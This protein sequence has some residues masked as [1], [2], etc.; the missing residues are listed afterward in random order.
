M[1]A[2]KFE[3]KLKEFDKARRLYERALSDLGKE[4]LDENFLIQ[5]VK[6]EIKQKEFDRAKILF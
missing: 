3:E 1:K 2:A 6:F 5:F 4:A